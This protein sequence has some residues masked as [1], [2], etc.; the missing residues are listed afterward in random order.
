MFIKT[1]ARILVALNSN[2]K[3][4]QLAA[5]V[6]TGL[7]LGFV[8]AGNL[9]W[10]TILLLVLFTKVHYGMTMLVAGLCKLLLPLLAPSL[11]GLGGL[12]LSAGFL[13]G[14]FT[15]LYNLP[16]AP[17]MRFNNTLVAGGLCLGLALWLPTFFASRVLIVAYRA[18]L[19]PRIAESKLMKAFLKI[20]LVE[21][22]AG[23]T[24]SLTR[25]VRAAE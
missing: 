24:S 1:F 22:L 13:S 9:A 12:V 8:P 20:P 23:A 4:E 6:A 11:D 17:L 18:R 21:S 5:A 7:L 3:K 10:L 25:L 2:V 14:V 19:A 15:W 16:I